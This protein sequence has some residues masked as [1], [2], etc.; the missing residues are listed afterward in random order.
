MLVSQNTANRD[1]AAYRQVSDPTG[2]Q[3][4]PYMLGYASMSTVSENSVYELKSG[5]MFHRTSGKVGEHSSRPTDGKG[6]WRLARRV[7]PHL[8]SKSR[9]TSQLTGRGYAVRC[10]AGQT[11]TML[12]AM[13]HGKHG[14]CC[15]LWC[16][17][18]LDYAVR[19]GAGQTWTWARTRARVG[20]GKLY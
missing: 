1:G 15:A 14:L 5:L 19:Y 18:N 9:K 7:S 16:T 6:A 20:V 4:I 10:G 2:L 3:M 11:W 12:C 8:S 17:A 13:V